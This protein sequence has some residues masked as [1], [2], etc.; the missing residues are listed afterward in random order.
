MLPEGQTP[1]LT[2]HRGP[3]VP[4]PRHRATGERDDTLSE[5][6]EIWPG[7]VDLAKESGLIYRLHAL[8]NA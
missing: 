4:A 3:L 7:T 6:R 1:C 5:L 8:L 2:T